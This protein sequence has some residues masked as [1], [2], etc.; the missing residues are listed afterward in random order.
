M[1]A[2]SLDFSDYEDAVVHQS[3]RSVNAD[4]IVTRSG[5]DF[6]KSTIAVYSPRELLAVVASV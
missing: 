2:L 5:A 3:A 1:E 4:G 6:K